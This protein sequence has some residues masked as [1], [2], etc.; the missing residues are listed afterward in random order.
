MEALIDDIRY[1]LPEHLRSQVVT[2]QASKAEIDALKTALKEALEIFLRDNKGQWEGVVPV[3]GPSPSA[4][5]E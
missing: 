1:D 3:F 5:K 2:G 4:D